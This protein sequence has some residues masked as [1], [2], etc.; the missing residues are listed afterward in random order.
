MYY[1]APWN[2]SGFACTSINAVASPMPNACT[3]RNLYVNAG[4]AGIDG[5][6]GIVTLYKGAS[7]TA[8]TC[9]IATGTTC[10]DTGHTVAFSSNS[11]FYISVKSSTAGSD[12]LANI[13]ATFQCN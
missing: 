12:L 9:T 13:R 4:T 8:L 11:G 7:A 6:S 3:A 1:L 5:T 2:T 10:Q